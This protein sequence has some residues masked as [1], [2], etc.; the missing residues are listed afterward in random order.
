MRLATDDVCV[1]LRLIYPLTLA[2]S[3]TALCVRVALCCPDG[4]GHQERGYSRVH[5]RAKWPPRRGRMVGDEG[6][7]GFESAR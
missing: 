5:S 6:K 4:V 2:L 1:R 3:L 7:R